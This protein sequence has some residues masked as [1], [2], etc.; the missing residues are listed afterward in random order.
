M[1][2]YENNYKNLKSVV[3]D[4]RDL[5]VEIVPAAGARTASILF[6]SADCELLWQNTGKVHAPV[7]YAQPFPDGEKAG[8]DEMFPTINKC[9]CPDFPWRGVE[10]PDHGEV[11]AIPWS[12]EK[13]TEDVV[14]SVFGVRL[15]YRLSKRVR[16]EGSSIKTVY[17]VENL[18]PF[19]M[20][21]LYAAHPLFNVDKDDRIIVPDNLTSVINA[22]PSV[23]L[24]D[25]GREYG[26]TKEFSDMPEKTCDGYRKYYFRQKNTAG[27]SVLRREK[28]GFEIKMS[29]S[30]D[31]LPWLGIWMNSGGWDSQY[32]LALEP[33]SAPMD[34]PVAA[35]AWGNESVLSPCEVREWALDIEISDFSF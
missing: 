13:R 23:D 29:V 10:L 33:A 3:L 2:V 27:W 6:K 35:R 4:N 21:F 8:F 5:R 14:F 30:A 9:L 15:P 32:N 25:Y 31:K 12:D 20:P 26:W 18:S 28:Q 24:P 16:L 34:D 22:V 11:W 7:S 17:R 1:N 19:P